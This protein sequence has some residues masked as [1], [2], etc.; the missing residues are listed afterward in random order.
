MK[1]MRVFELAAMTWS[2]VRSLNL[3]G[4]NLPRPK[5][6]KVSAS[7][8]RVRYPGTMLHL[9]ERWSSSSSFTQAVSDGSIGSLILTRSLGTGYRDMLPK[10]VATG[11][12]RCVDPRAS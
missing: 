4:V 8:H 5:A 12:F 2:S 1:G 9:P 6:E 10:L 3:D 11:P 7:F